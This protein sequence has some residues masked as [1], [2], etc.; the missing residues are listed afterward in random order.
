LPVST[1]HACFSGTASGAWAR[2]STLNA[3]YQPPF[4]ALGSLF[5]PGLRPGI[6]V[7]F[8]CKAV[9]NRPQEELACVIGGLNEVIV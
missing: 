2:N 9:N 5:Y 6:I 1:M 7:C 4:R 8:R 3:I